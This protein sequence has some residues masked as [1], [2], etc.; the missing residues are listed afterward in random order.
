[1]KR[2]VAGIFVLVLLSA[3]ALAEEPPT[4]ADGGWWKIPYPQPFDVSNLAEQPS[5][6]RVEGNRF[7]D[8]RGDTVVFR[9]VSIADPD[10]VE[11]DGRWSKALFEAVRSW[12]ANVVRIPV[13]PAAWRGRGREAYLELLD[14]AVVW[15]SEVDLY[16]VVDWHSIGNLE[17]G[18]FQHPMYDTSKSETLDFW[19]TVAARY[20]GISTVALYEIFNEPTGFGGRLGT[21][22]WPAWRAF[23]EEVIGVVRAHDPS[24][25]PLVAGFD[26]AYDLTPVRRLP[27]RAGGVGYVSHPYP[28]KVEPP[29]EPKWKRDFGFVAAE[30]PLVVTEFGFT[31]GGGVPVDGDETYGEAI[32]AYL[33][34]LGASWIAWCFDPDWGPQLIEDWQYTPTLSGAF[35]RRALRAGD[36][37]PA[38]TDNRSEQE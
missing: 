23:N 3:I 31:P 18:L 26:W 6:V 36:T 12:G 1:M 9:G 33:D 28:Q 15:A 27:V 16:L 25:I 22:S 19:R 35:F 11:R 21:V 30:H 32:V 8:A 13:H 34:R 7:V 4:E 38:G 2:A 24:A 17:S 10:K 14:Q 37:P 5:E 29:W 20:A